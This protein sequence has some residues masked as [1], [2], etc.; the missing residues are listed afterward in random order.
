[1][2]LGTRVRVLSRITLIGMK[3]ME[4]DDLEI[5]NTDA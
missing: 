5:D 1:M 4:R 2:D 3:E